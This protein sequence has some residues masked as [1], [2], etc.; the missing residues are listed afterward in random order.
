[1]HLIHTWSDLAG[2]KY[3]GFDASK[4]V[5]NKDFQPTLRYIGNP[6]NKQQPLKTYDQLKNNPFI[7]SPG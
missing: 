3:D 4:S 2:L 6:Y 1:M 7:Y 5:V